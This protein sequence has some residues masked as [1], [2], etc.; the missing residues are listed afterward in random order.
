MYFT[1]FLLKFLGYADISKSL[2]LK[3][4]FKMVW[5]NFST[6]L[7]SKFIFRLNCNP[8]PK[9]NLIDVIESHQYL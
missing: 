8:T 1:D 4:Q 3:T 9:I 6:Y 2:I 7:N 5:D